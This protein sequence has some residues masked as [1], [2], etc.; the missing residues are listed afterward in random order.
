MLEYVL[1]D[2]DMVLIMSV[3]PGF[4]GQK[5]LPSTFGKVRA[6]RAMLGGR[7]CHVQVDGGVTPENAGELTRAGADV[8][9]SGSSF[10]G[11]PPLAERLAVFR[12][13]AE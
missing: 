7:A 11:H 4:G 10:F 6:V 9:V 8:L 13:A 3:N 12:A 2:V 1:D 5:F